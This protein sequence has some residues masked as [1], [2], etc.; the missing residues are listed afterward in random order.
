MIKITKNHYVDTVLH[1]IDIIIR[2]L[3][4]EL[5]QKLD[6]LNIGITGEQFVVLD[7][8]AYYENIYQQKLSEILMKDKSSTTR[9]IKVL[10]D[11]KLITKEVGSVNNRL[12]YTLKITPKGKKIV[13]EN[14]PI[15]K[16]YLT[17][18]FKHITDDE[19][20]L[21]HTLSRKFKK[22]LVENTHE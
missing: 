13:D 21:L 4:L 22:D 14:I 16:E 7:T 1:S 19:I 6:K 8:I 18:I 10:A 9:I 15:M 3:K 17:E 12:V 2:G 20:E 5:K 11:Q